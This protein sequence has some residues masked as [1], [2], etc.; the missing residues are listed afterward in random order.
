MFNNRNGVI[1]V[2]STL[3]S[4]VFP[5]VTP[6]IP[7]SSLCLRRIFQV[8]MRAIQWLLSCVTE[9]PEEQDTQQQ[10][11]LRWSFL[12]LICVFSQQLLAILFACMETLAVKW[13]INSYL[14]HRLCLKIGTESLL[15]IWGRLC[16]LSLSGKRAIKSFGRMNLFSL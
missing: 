13:C 16:S 6:N 2:E 1:T 10:G 4:L 14:L 15:A 9:N 3:I 8:L 12:V 11:N 5:K 7:S